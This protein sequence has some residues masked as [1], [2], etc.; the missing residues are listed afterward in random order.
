VLA[1]FSTTIKVVLK[2]N[3]NYSFGINLISV[4]SVTRGRRRRVLNQSKEGIKTES[5]KRNKLGY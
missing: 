4:K 5:K 1:L 2:Y 3:N